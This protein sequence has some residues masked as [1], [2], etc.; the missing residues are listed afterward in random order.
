MS[1]KDSVDY[2]GKVGSLVLFW[3]YNNSG[4]GGGGGGVGVTVKICYSYSRP[5]E[6]D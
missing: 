1:V 3:P 2:K 4:D 5:E 6:T